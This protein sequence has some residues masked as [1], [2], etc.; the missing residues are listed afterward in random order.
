[1][2]AHLRFNRSKL[3]PKGNDAFSYYLNNKNGQ[4]IRNLTDSQALK[5]IQQMISEV[6]YSDYSS[7]FYSSEEDDKNQHSYFKKDE[8]FYSLPENV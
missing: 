2:R 7:E 4:A 3:K 5:N 8:K 1:M 6:R